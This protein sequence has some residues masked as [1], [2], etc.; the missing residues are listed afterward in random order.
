MTIINNKHKFI[1]VHVPKNAGTSITNMLASFSTPID[2]EIG[3]TQ[4][5][6]LLQPEYIK[7]YRISK[8]S[9]SFDLETVLGEVWN[10]YFKFAMVR[11]PFSR[12]ISA[13]NFLRKWNS[14]NI[15][16]HNKILSYNDINDFISSDFIL[17]EKI[18]D[19]IFNKQTYWLYDK[20]NE[21]MMIDKYLKIEDIDNEIRSLA[22]NIPAL[23]N[24]DSG[25][26]QRL[27]SSSGLE[28]NFN[29]ILTKNS[30]DILY[31]IYRDDF[32][33]FHYNN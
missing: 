12:F 17:V 25:I 3:G 33:K 24:Y 14:G 2:I 28:K 23:N 21:I 4:I 15:N 29:E 10:N 11:N 9:T 22:Q 16:F 19:S 6:E 20:S 27:N 26:L 13:Y 8:H 32:D 30:L 31:T 5:G 7:R 18:P 1:F